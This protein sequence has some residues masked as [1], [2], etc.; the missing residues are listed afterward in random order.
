MQYEL[1]K[2]KEGGISISKLCVI[3]QK[4]L[5]KRFINYQRQRDKKGSF[6]ENTTRSL[7]AGEQL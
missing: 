7:S 2:L 1:Y 5:I 4:R 6:E 3:N